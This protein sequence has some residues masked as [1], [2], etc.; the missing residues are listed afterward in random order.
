MDVPG[1]ALITGAASGIGRA[2]AHTFARDGCLGLALIDL[3]AASLQ[4]VK[5]EIEKQNRPINGDKPLRI[6]T[7][8]IDITDEA[9]VNTTITTIASTFGRIDY[10]INAAGIAKKHIGGAAHAATADWLNVIN[11]N[12]TGTF[13]VLRACALIMLEQSPLLSSIDARPLSRGSIVNFSSIL[14]H[15]GIQMST[16]YTAAKHG[17][18]GL[19]KTASEDYAGRGLRVNAVCPGYTETP[20]TTADEDVRRVM[21]KQVKEACPMGRMGRP[22][23]IADAVV[24][25]AGGRSSFVTGTSLLVDGGYAQR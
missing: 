2:T 1:I 4:I 24:F 5:S 15:V 13:F 16:A 21:E 17:V 25:L 18:I 22:Q 6:E 23:E 7:Y 11:V 20:M 14:G 8:A 3:N 19:T 10:C 9:A 12:L